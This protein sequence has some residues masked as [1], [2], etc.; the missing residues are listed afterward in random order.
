MNNRFVWALRWMLLVAVIVPDVWAQVEAPARA[1]AGIVAEK[2]PVTL[3]EIRRIESR[4]KSLLKVSSAAT[5]NIQIGEAN[6]SGVVVSEDGYVLTAAHV[7]GRP[8]R[9]AW[10]TFADGKQVRAR[11]LGSNNSFGVD[12]GLMKIE[13]PGPWPTVPMADNKVAQV[14][15]WCFALGFPGGYDKD[16]GPVLRLG[17]VINLQE[18]VMWTDCTLLGG[19]SG[20][21]LFNLDG[22]VIGIHSRIARPTTANFHAPIHA[23][24]DQWDKL[25]AGEIWAGPR[26]AFL[27]TDSRDHEKGA[28]I[29]QV[30]PQSP[31][32]KAGVLPQ[33]V[34]AKFGQE[35]VKNAQHL[36]TLIRAYKP[37]DKV[38]VLILRN[39]QEIKLEIELGGR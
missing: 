20:G 7:S 23:F 3:D 13:E 14:G 6:G 27:G 5:V 36:T 11:S 29:E 1:P 31:A 4:V 25:V 10:V 39:G 35:N 22:K 2:P 12:A 16:R 38:E 37:G 33:D 26:T 15:E 28:V 30:R 8:N 24:R 19:D 32:A 34:L 9:T 18:N 17:R 21:P